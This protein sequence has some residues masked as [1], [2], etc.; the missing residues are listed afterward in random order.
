[1]TALQRVTLAF[2]V[3]SLAGWLFSAASA[4]SGFSSNSVGVR[5][6]D[7]AG[8]LQIE[9]IK[10]RAFSVGVEE[11]GQKTRYESKFDVLLFCHKVRI[12]CASDH[13]LVD[14]TTWMRKHVNAVY[15][16]GEGRERV[17]YR[18][19]VEEDHSLATAT[20]ETMQ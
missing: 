15:S 20:V 18:A 10:D 14:S 5:Y 7:K 13:R 1:M 16:L 12:Q 2:V 6:S 4:R 3:L 11:G 9:V 8:Q 19:N 17:R